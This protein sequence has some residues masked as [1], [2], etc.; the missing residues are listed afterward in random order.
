MTYENDT[1][2]ELIAAAEALANDLQERLLAK[3]DA[4]Q[5]GVISAEESLAV[6]QAIVD[7]KTAAILA[8]FDLDHDGNVT[9]TEISTV[10]QNEDAFHPYP[11]GGF[12]R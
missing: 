7:A 3:Y 10:P 1:S 4:N 11:G 9:S 12:R 2:D 6:Q 5:D 8:K